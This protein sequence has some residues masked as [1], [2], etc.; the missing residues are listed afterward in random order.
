M[1]ITLGFDV[2]GTL[3]DTNGVV[4][5]L[6]SQVGD[7]G[8]E[9]SRRW[10]EKQLEYSFRRGL[11]QHYQDFAVCTRQALDH[12]VAATGVALTEAQKSALLEVYQE[13]PA[14]PDVRR[15]LQRAL[16]AQMRLF[17]FSNGS[18]KAVAKILSGAGI[19]DCFL[20]IISVDELRSFKPNPAVYCHFLRRTGARGN[21]AWLV[22]SNPFDVIGAESAGLRAVWVQ[23]S[24]DA[25]FDPWG[26]APSLT[27]KGLD[28]LAERVQAAGKDSV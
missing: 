5:M 14:F 1:S 13:L 20:D 18:A 19:A 25:L 4:E 26:I 23:R 16:E 3:I 12:T 15:C 17:A 9:F 2:Y 11:M 7:L 8:P 22:S 21:T 28:E 10:R 27:V 6:R 24:P